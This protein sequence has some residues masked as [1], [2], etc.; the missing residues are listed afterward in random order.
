MMM[1][2]KGIYSQYNTAIRLHHIYINN[3]NNHISDQRLLKRYK[4]WYHMWMLFKI[5]DT[6]FVALC[7]SFVSNCYWFY[8]ISIIPQE[9]YNEQFIFF[10]QKLSVVS[11]KL[12]L[13]WAWNLDTDFNFTRMNILKLDFCHILTNEM[14]I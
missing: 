9:I 3:N 2:F 5:I 4:P 10:P 11:A 14:R 13:K 1:F 12:R 8:L 7:C 6:Y